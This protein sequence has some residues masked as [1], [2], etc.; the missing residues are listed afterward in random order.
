MEG[1]STRQLKVARLLQKDLSDIFQKDARNFISSGLISVTVVRVSP[2]LSLAKVYLSIFGA[3]EKE[4]VIDAI[5]SGVR[6]I[7]HKLAVRIK[8][9]MRK[10]PELVF[11]EDDSLDY[12][13]KIDDL[14]K[15]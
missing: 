1:Y 10:I 11:Y 7:R 5:Q 8:N 3:K 14:L 13:D 6:E 15:K 12:I 4:N 9:Q 2:D